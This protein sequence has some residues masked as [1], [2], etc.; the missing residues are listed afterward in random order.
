ML[1]SDGARIAYILCACVRENVWL[2][3]RGT[4]DH[5]GAVDRL[6]PFN[7]QSLVTCSSISNQLNSFLFL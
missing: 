6:D 5:D 4:L 2:C 3:H 7:E 1:G